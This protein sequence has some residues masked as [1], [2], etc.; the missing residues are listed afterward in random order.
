MRGKINREERKNEKLIDKEE[1]KIFI[2]KEIEKK[3]KMRLRS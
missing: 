2:D 3:E 1:R